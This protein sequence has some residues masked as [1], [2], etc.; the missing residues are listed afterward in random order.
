[1]L[2]LGNIR[3]TGFWEMVD[4]AAMRDFVAAR[5]AF[6]SGCG[7]EDTCLGGCKESAEVCSGSAWARDPLLEA[8][9]H[10]AS[11]PE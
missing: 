6:C 8:Y 10:L 4:S 11:K 9:G 3:S 5:P 2:I 7:V 1:M